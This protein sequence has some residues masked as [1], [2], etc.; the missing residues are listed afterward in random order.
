MEKRQ[1]GR[2]RKVLMSAFCYA[3]PT[4]GSEP[5]V[6]WQWAVQMAR[7]HDLTVITQSKNRPAI[8]KAVAELSQHQPVPRFIYF[9]REQ[10]SQSLRKRRTGLL[11][12][13]CLLWHKAAHEFIA[14][15]AS[16]RSS[17]D[18]MH[19]VTIAGFRIKTAIWG[20]GA[21]SIWGPVGG[22]EN[23]PPQLLPWRHLRVLLPELARNV[24]N[25]I[26]DWPFSTLRYRLRATT[27]TLAST[28]EMQRL[29]R[30]MGYEAQVMPTIGLRTS[31]FAYRP[32]AITQGPL[33]LLFVGNLIAL[34]GIHLAVEALAQSGVD[35]TLTFIGTGNLEKPMRKRVRE[36][37]IASRVTFAGRLPLQEVMR[38]YQ[39]FDILV[40]PSFHDTGGYAVIEAMCSGLP[41]ICLDSGGPAIAVQ[42]ECGV[43]VP[44]GSRKAVIKGLSEAIKMY[45]GDRQLLLEHSRAA[46]Q[47]VLEQYDWDKK[48]EQLALVY[49]KAV[50]LWAS[51]RSETDYETA[52]GLMGMG[53][54]FILTRSIVATMLLIVAI[55]L[56]C[57]SSVSYLKKRARQVVED[58]VPGLI[59]AGQA[60]FNLSQG[61]DRTLLILMAQ[62]EQQRAHYQAEA[63]EFADRTAEALKNYESSIFTA[64]DRK[65]FDQ[66]VLRRQEY[67]RVRAQVF[68]LLEQDR[69]AEGE[70]LCRQNLVPAYDGY[71]RAGEALF[72]YNVKAGQRQT[73]NI[74]TAGAAT[75]LLVAALGVILFIGG[76][77]IGFLK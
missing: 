40:F 27:V 67:E 60:D 63:K 21:P 36:L 47:T 59:Y 66:L 74:F 45:D 49:E 41:V 50:T 16:D 31:E 12:L 71:R 68:A 77:V 73:N 10:H 13:Y 35:A 15:F 61:F 42:K 4:R 55:S 29:I 57:F 39:E 76:F 14:N 30:R 52:G 70:A 48:G 6:G 28:Q 37:G 22:I 54:R 33:K 9:D 3:N 72:S 7:H 65:L 51:K 34:K 23:S 5:E 53:R 20:H 19:H 43:K 56:L 18:L 8:E 46:R 24:H 38:A 26:Q 69:R 11:Q 62:D 32:R 25:K 64:E 75:Q 17:F 58:T 2:L 44:I 1:S